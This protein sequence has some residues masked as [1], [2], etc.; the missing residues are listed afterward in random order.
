MEYFGNQSRGTGLQ[1]AEQS[2]DRER[3]KS[4]KR[5]DGREEHSRAHSGSRLTAQRE[6]EGTRSSP[7]HLHNYHS[8]HIGGPHRPIERHDIGRLQREEKH[9][10]AVVQ[11][12]SPQ[13]VGAHLSQSVAQDESNGVGVA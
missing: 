2:L 10:E 12:D 6:E 11:S 1:D 5:Y 8:H 13:S 4:H 7:R 9:P 3:G